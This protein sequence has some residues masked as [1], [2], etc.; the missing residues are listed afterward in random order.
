[1]YP[2]TFEFQY[3]HNRIATRDCK[4]VLEKEHVRLEMGWKIYDI[5]FKDIKSYTLHNTQSVKLFI[6]TVKDKI[7]LT[8]NFNFIDPEKP[9]RFFSA[10]DAAVEG[11]FTAPTAVVPEAEVKPGVWL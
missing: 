4:A 8:V 9:L 7:S 5:D 1:M 11:A 2:R 6:E 3:T 10:F